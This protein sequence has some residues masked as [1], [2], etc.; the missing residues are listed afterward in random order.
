SREGIDRTEQPPM[1]GRCD[2]KRQRGDEHENGDAPGHS[3]RAY[4]S[5]SAPVRANR[6]KSHRRA[7]FLAMR[8]ALPAVALLLGACAQPVAAARFIRADAARL[9]A[10]AAAAKRAA[11]RLGE[12]N[13]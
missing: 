11:D 6:N 10:D 2:E 8:R 13:A 12:P 7:S 4:G 9:C 3:E 5:R 1:H